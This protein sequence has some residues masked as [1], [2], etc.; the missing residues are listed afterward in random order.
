V[1]AS[2]VSRRLADLGHFVF[3]IEEGP[4]ACVI[5]FP[6]GY[7]AWRAAATELVRGRPSAPPDR[8]RRP[9]S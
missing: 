8:S 7:T 3:G 1:D 9:A 5:A 4:R 6:A 2:S